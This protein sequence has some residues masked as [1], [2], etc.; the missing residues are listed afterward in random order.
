MGHTGWPAAALGLQPYPPVPPPPQPWGRVW[1]QLPLY[2][3]GLDPRSALGTVTQDA[4]I[5]SRL[6]TALV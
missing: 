5:F 1:E 4:H 3:M 2:P 6:V